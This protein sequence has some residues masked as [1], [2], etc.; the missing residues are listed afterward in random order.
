MHA[1][2]LEAE[3][4]NRR[5]ISILYGTYNNFER[6]GTRRKSEEIENGVIK[7]KRSMCVEI[8]CWIAMRD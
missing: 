4:C 7:K 8:F 5:N 2:E 6:V 3:E 1:N